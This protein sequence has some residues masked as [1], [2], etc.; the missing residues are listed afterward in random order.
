MKNPLAHETRARR[1]VALLVL[2]LAGALF[3]FAVRN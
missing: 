1:A 2:G 3:L